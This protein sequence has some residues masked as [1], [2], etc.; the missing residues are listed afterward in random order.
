MQHRADWTLVDVYANWTDKPGV[1]QGTPDVIQLFLDKRF[2][3]ALAKVADD[4]RCALAF[5]T[6]PSPLNGN[7]LIHVLS[8]RSP[9]EFGVRK[10]EDCWS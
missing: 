1:S 7:N 8:Q 9:K 6:Y 10:Y 2:N 3:E 5:A 4:P